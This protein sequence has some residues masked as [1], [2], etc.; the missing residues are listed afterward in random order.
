[1][2]PAQLEALGEDFG[3]DPVCVG[4]FEFVER[5]VGDHTTLE[6]SEDYYDKDHVY[7]DR[8]I[9]RLVTDETVRT[10][11]LRSGDLQVIDRVGTTDV[12]GL[13]AD[14]AVKVL[15][16]VSNAYLM[17]TFNIAN[18]NGIGEAPGEVDSPFVDAAI[19]EAFELAIDRD[20]IN[21][22]V[23]SGLAGS[24]VRADLAGQPVLRRQHLPATRPRPSAGARRRHPA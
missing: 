18:A 10:A 14:P 13:R 6:R 1:M 23:Y 7:L 17:M 24:P 16:K 4:P 19:R 22:I 9:Y 2:S 15:D 11:N 20:Q 8:I 5:V 21:Q 12:E 3:N